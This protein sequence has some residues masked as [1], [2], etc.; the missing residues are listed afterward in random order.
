[1]R[2]VSVLVLIF[3][4]YYDSI[5]SYDLQFHPLMNGFGV[6]Q[7]SV[8]SIKLY[9][10]NVHSMSSST[11]L[12]IP[13]LS[14]EL[15]CPTWPK[16]FCADSKIIDFTR[17]WNLQTLSLSSILQTILH[18]FGWHP[19][20]LLCLFSHLCPCQMISI[21]DLLDYHFITRL[22]IDSRGWS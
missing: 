17:H 6:F 18:W 15:K 21:T 2:S 13:D 20:A 7:S 19:W 22:H 10:V 3:V 1:M 9:S 5:W 12:T 16:C 14:G 4:V 8:V 11:R